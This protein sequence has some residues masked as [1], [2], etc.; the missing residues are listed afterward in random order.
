ITSSPSVTAA[1]SGNRSSSGLVAPPILDDLG[2]ARPRVRGADGDELGAVV[3]GLEAAHRVAMDS[4]R[5]PLLHVP[6]L[7]LELDPC[8]PADEHIHLFLVLV[9]VRE[10]NAEARRD[11]DVAEAGVL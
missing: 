6:D 2:V 1:V 9:L 4:Y 5:V 8:A 11:P 3:A 7:V 10:G